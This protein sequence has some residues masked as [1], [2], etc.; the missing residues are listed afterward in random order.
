MKRSDIERWNEILAQPHVKKEI[1]SGYCHQDITLTYN[2][3]ILAHK[4]N[5]FK[6]GKL[7]SS[8]YAFYDAAIFQYYP[9]LIEVK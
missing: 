8:G 7:I 5:Y 4:V 1:I 2:G 6:R 3:R 9:H